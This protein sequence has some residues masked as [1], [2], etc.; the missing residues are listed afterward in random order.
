[1][2]DPLQRSAMV[3]DLVEWVEIE[4]SY[5][6]INLCFFK[7]LSGDLSFDTMKILFWQTYYK[8]NIN[9]IEYKIEFYFQFKWYFFVKTM[10]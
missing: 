1:M 5:L 8:T 9:F 2:Q 3:Q 4:S 10:H 6:S 7:R